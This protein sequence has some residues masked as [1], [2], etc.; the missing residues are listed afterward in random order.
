[1][2]YQQAY[3][4]SCSV[5]LRGGK[6]FQI[7]AA[8]PTI[9]PKT[10]AL[11]ERIGVYVPPVSFPARPTPEEIE[12][13]PLSLLYHRSQNGQRLLGQSKYLGVD[14]TGRFGNYFS[15]CLAV[16][17][18]DSAER[19]FLPIELWRSRT[20]AS[21]ES[22]TVALPS[23]DRPEAGGVIDPLRVNEFLMMHNRIDH[24]AALVT[25]VEAALGAGR[26][27]IIVDENESI[28]LWI[29]SVSYALPRHL[30][31]L[32][33]FNT[34]VKN[35]YQSDVL[36]TG[37]T[38]DSDFAF[39]PYE[40]EHQYSVFDFDGNRFSRFAPTAFASN[41]EAAY[42]AGR[43]E[44]LA[45]FSRFVERVAPDLSTDDLAIAFGCYAL[46][47]GM[48]AV[49]FNH[50]D[51]L[52]WC[53]SRVALLKPEFISSI[54]TAVGK[55]PNAASELAASFAE[56][57]IAVMQGGTKETTRDAVERAYLRFIFQHC[58]TLARESFDRLVRGLQISP[59]LMAIGQELRPLWFEKIRSVLDPCRLCEILGIG[60]RLGLLADCGEIVRRLA[61]TVIAPGLSDLSV[62]QSILRQLEAPLATDLISGLAAYLQTRASNGDLFHSLRSFLAEGKVLERM[63]LCARNQSALELYYR[64]IGQQTMN[65]PDLRVDS[66]R[67]CL[68]AAQ[69]FSAEITPSRVEV[70]FDAVW[71]RS[72]PTAGEALLVMD[73]VGDYIVA[74]TS[75][76]GR[77]GEFLAQGLDLRH[78]IPERDAL[79]ERLSSQ[80]M[81]SALGATGCIVDA[82]A[83]ARGL[84][85]PEADLDTLIIRAVRIARSLE[86][87]PR[88]ALMEMA[89]QRLFEIQDREKHRDLLVRANVAG[90]RSFVSIYTRHAMASLSRQGAPAS[91][92]VAT[93]FWIW[94]K[95]S[96]SLG[97]EQSRQLLNDVLRRSVK[98]WRQSDF[99]MAA[100]ALGEDEGVQFTWKQWLQQGSGYGFVGWL[101]RRFVILFALTI[102]MASGSF[103]GGMHSGY[104]CA[105]RAEAFESPE[106]FSSSRVPSTQ[107]NTESKNKTSPLKSRQ[108]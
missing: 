99:Q 53:I 96:F 4:T 101:A 23:I 9:D 58:D 95:A 3:Y 84:R 33:T 62:Q 51:V 52:K 7:N 14:Y 18:E 106:G 13:F 66:F 90:E 41:V 67:R 63:E 61:E 24:V 87:V 65:R 91:R 22:G 103:A 39:S 36:I 71:Q 17:D 20:W 59:A 81:L 76:P 16:P 93:L 28:A 50:A 57:Y 21:I 74:K 11:I 70:A 77:F 55:A 92:H 8:S 56:L 38:R 107:V 10:L 27:L 44:G 15:H 34:Y 88:V 108:N 97:E 12:G 73:A 26:R 40:V 72:L 46:S 54:V 60:D 30:A 80:A 31:W 1:M 43:S 82:L 37:T 94:S 35:P 2:S 83:I 85:S 48:P 6:G 79:A 29:A 32:L 102:G 98:H 100:I 104:R 19:D 78:D 5:G 47:C 86:E 25:A 64:I 89:A 68:S 69:S 49:G 75:I 45:N 105:E 42:R